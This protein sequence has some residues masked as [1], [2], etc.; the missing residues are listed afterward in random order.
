MVN[1]QK[2]KEM[3]FMIVPFGVYKLVEF[4]TVRLCH[5][6]AA[7]QYVDFTCKRGTHTLSGPS[8]LIA[9]HPFNVQH[10]CQLLTFLSSVRYLCKISMGDKG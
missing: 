3:S 7:C 10:V 4:P 9:L 2:E 8:V 1:P 5:A 6:F